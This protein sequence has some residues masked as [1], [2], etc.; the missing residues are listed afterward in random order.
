MLGCLHNEEL[1]EFFLAKHYP[2]DEIKEAERRQDLRHIWGRNELPAGFR[3]EN[4]KSRGNLQ[5]LGAD[6]S[7]AH[8]RILNLQ[9]QNL[10]N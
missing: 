1:R 6:E 2:G 5:N 8:Q 7:A 4:L 10:W 3:W 9:E